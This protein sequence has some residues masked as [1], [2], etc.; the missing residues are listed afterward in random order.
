MLFFWCRWVERVL[1]EMFKGNT[2]TKQQWLIAFLPSLSGMNRAW[3]SPYYPPWPVWF[4]YI[5]PHYLTNGTIFGRGVGGGGNY[6]T[7]ILFWISL[8]LLSEKSLILRIMRDIINVH[9]SWRN[10]SVFLVT[11]QWDFNFSRQIFEKLSDIKFHENPS[12]GN[13]AVPCGRRDRQTGRT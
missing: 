7:L 13:Q 10:V 1:V 5:F 11:L 12:S 8:K 9:R 6:W 2:R 4:Y 3:A